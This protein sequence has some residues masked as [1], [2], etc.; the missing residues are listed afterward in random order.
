M[1]KLKNVLVSLRFLNVVTVCIYVYLS[2]S[3][4]PANHEAA[5]L[6]TAATALSLMAGNVLNDYYDTET[7]RIN[8]PGRPSLVKLYGKKRTL[9][10]YY[11][12][13]LLAA[14]SV[15]FTRSVYATG[16]VLLA[17]LLLTF[18]AQYGKYA[19]AAGNVLVAFLSGLSVFAP[20]L[21]CTEHLA[22]QDKWIGLHESFSR[23]LLLC[24]LLA[25]FFSLLREWIKD[26]EDYEGDLRTGLRTGV[27]QTGLPAALRI[28]R[29]ISLLYLLILGALVWYLQSWVPLVWSVLFASVCLKLWGGREK[30]HFRM[31]SALL[32]VVFLSGIL[33]YFYL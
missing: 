1:K 24:S 3:V 31:A 9:R 20:Y 32:K 28:A 27:I 30:Q 17:N 21:V 29:V 33:A 10:S 11:A 14:L 22:W 5:L 6:F 13:L 18:Y 26:M 7:D 19:G 15:L 2:F 12:L 23:P 25:F 16:I 8:K 4:F